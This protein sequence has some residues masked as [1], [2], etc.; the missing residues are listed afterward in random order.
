MYKM[1]IMSQSVTYW[2]TDWPTAVFCQKLWIATKNLSDLF[3]M[4][5]RG[6]TL[7]QVTATTP[8][9]PTAVRTALSARSSRICTATPPPLLSPLPLLRQNDTKPGS[10]KQLLLTDEFQLTWR[11]RHCDQLESAFELAPQ[12]FND[13]Q[14]ISF[15]PSPW[16]S[17]PFPIHSWLPPPPAASS[18]PPPSLAPPR[19]SPLCPLSPELLF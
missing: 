8:S 14:V 13:I 7:L 9:S 3:T 1:K 11:K 18:S 4:V 12:Q 17:F 15:Q 6:F 2:L 10:L 19:E 5:K 16:C